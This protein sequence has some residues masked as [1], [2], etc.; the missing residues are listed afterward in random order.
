MR[1]TFQP[2]D[3]NQP[4]MDWYPS[5]SSW[6]LPRRPGPVS[7]GFL[8]SAL[9]AIIAI[10]V[11]YPLWQTSFQGAIQNTIKLQQPEPPFDPNIGAVLPQ[12]R[13]V[14][15]YAVPGAEATGPA[16]EP[17]PDMLDRLKQQGAAYEALDP[18]HSVQL[19][20]DLV[21]SVPD[22]SPGPDKTYSHHVDEQTV[23]SYIDFCQKNHLLLF[24][25]LNFGQAQVM[26]EV[27]SF[28]PYLQKYRFVHMAVD[29]EWMF[30]RHDGIPGVNLSN[31]RSSDLNPIIKALAD[32]PIKYHVPRKMLIL[33]Q[34]RPSG[35]GLAN[36]FSGSDAELAD[37]Q[38]LLSEKRV[39]VVLH[40]DSVGGYQG[41]HE[42]KQQQYAEWVKRDMNLYQNFRYGGFKLF[43]RIEAP[44]GLMT[45]AEVLKL[46]PAPMVITYGN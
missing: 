36:P 33:H 21:V 6:R 15:Y 27:N 18:R 42:D 41:D 5:T 22:S 30:P 32:I 38:K 8:L 40:V 31:V 12:H 7:V 43:Y 46:D 39:D 1:E 19:G 24:L 35:D 11:T 10:V 4:D 17:T 28:L 44:T 13:V 2:S 23:R 45:P 14:A 37:K 26:K 9:M 25:D 29:P 34:Y 20:I 3:D 16:Y